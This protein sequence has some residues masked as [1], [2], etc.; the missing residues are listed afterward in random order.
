MILSS[1]ELDFAL[2][3]FLP[4]LLI[5]GWISF[6]LLLL[7]LLGPVIGPML[8]AQLDQFA[9]KN[10]SWGGTAKEGLEV[11]LDLG[12][13]AVADVALL[14]RPDGLT[15]E[16]WDDRRFKTGIARLAALAV[17]KG[18]EMST[19]MLR[20]TVENALTAWQRGERPKGL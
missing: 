1:P 9:E 13:E 6:I 7:K 4:L 2:V 19:Q 15:D 14:Q 5:A 8:K 3:A 11:M 12:L 16:Q 17:G 10:P 20:R 18:I